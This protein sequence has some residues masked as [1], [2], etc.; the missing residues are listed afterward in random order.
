MNRLIIA[1]ALGLSLAACGAEESAPEP[2]EPPTEA[3]AETEEE[4][5]AAP[6]AEEM[7]L[8]EDFAE[9]AEQEITAENLEAE[10]AALESELGEE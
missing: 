1:T 10:L 9:E 7:P 3:V 4:P 8:P 5:E 6:T 2:T